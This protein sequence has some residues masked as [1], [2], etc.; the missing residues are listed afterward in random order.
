MKELIDRLSE[1]DRKALIFGAIFLIPLILYFGV[2]SPFQ[3]SATQLAVQVSQQKEALAWMKTHQADAIA[4]Q[5]QTSSTKGQ[6]SRGRSLL[7]VVDESLRHANL[8]KSVKRIEPVGD[9]Q[10]NVRFESALFDNL[11]I[12][13]G[14]LAND[15]GIATSTITVV[16]RSESG[17]VDAQMVLSR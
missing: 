11:I 2:W 4:L 12:W 8:N 13:L 6:G 15:Q 17:L 5:K 9:G 1:K 16:Q 7:S 10:I 14:S 3:D